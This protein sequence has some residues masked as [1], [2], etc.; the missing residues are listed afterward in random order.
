MTTEQNGSHW[1]SFLFCMLTIKKK[2][3][4]HEKVFLKIDP[5]VQK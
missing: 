3:R 5:K 4:L 1:N 2:S